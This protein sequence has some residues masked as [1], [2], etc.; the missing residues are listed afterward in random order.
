VSSILDLIKFLKNLWGALAVAAILFPG[1]ATLLKLPLAVENSVIDFLYPVT[2]MLIATFSLLFLTAYKSELRCI[3]TARKLSVRSMGLGIL[4]LF[5]FL[6][7]RVEY[8]DINTRKQYHEDSTGFEYRESRS[9]GII[10]VERV[11]TS[12]TNNNV[13]EEEKYNYMYGDPIDILALFIFTMTFTAF[14][15]AFGSLGIHAFHQQKDTKTT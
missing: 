15:I 1:A 10:Q 3:K 2:P 6:F 13:V 9:K 11:K 7:V 8:L 5:A 14:T 4:G 12:V